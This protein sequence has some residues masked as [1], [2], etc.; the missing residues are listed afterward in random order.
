MA[1]VIKNYSSVK[2][3]LN[4]GKINNLKNI[5]KNG[6]N[7]CPKGDEYKK[8]EFFKCIAYMI[9]YYL[10]LR[11]NLNSKD[12]KNYQKQINEHYK[13]LSPEHKIYIKTKVTS[14]FTTNFLKN[15]LLSY[16]YTNTHIKNNIKNNINNT[17]NTNNTKDKKIIELLEDYDFENYQQVVSLINNNNNNKYI[18]YGKYIGSG[19]FAQVY[20]FKK[21]KVFRITNFKKYKEDRFKNYNKPTNLEQKIYEFSKKKEIN[22]NKYLVIINEK[23]P[24]CAVKIED[25]GKVGKDDDII[26]GVYE[27]GFME[28]K[29][30]YKLLDTRDLKIK[31]S[32][33]KLITNILIKLI[34]KIKCIHDNKIL[35]LDIKTENIMLFDSDDNN[36]FDIDINDISNNLTE[37]RNNKNVKLRQKFNVKFIDFGMSKSMNKNKNVKFSF[38]TKE[39]KLPNRY[40]PSSNG[41]VIRADFM[42][43]L[44]AI[45]RMF[46]ELINKDLLEIKDNGIEG[47]KFL[48]EEDIDNFFTSMKVSNNYNLKNIILDTVSISQDKKIIIP[49]IERSWYKYEGLKE[50][51]KK[52][53]TYFS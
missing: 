38:G 17:N 2:N 14:I 22:G 46:Q 8:C 40:Y 51:L 53:L 3:I 21:N 32:I 23:C 30:L 48:K 28:L 12:K 7:K 26:Y 35:H 5:G 39:Y 52:I 6:L 37:I 50:N 43:D 15:S 18:F 16:N 20:N 34:D 27:K 33:F 24:N 13:K 36:N 42:N 47:P 44:Y 41:L 49:C 9:S 10:L 19:G 11:D 25:W 4:S 29:S 31:K 45:S 1:E